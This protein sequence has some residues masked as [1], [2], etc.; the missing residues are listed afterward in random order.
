MGLGVRGKETPFSGLDILV[1]VVLSAGESTWE[2]ED[3]AV[4]SG[5]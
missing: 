1:T 3:V 5:D 4:H 2:E